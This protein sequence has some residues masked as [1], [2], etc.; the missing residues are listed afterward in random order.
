MPLFSGRT[1]LGV[2]AV[3]A[4][5]LG[6]FALRDVE[7][8]WVEA[9]CDAN[10]SYRRSLIEASTQHMRRINDLQEQAAKAAVIGAGR[11]AQARLGDVASEAE[12]LAADLGRVD[13]VDYK[14]AERDRAAAAARGIATA[15]RG[16]S[17]RLSGLTPGTFA[18][19]AAPLDDAADTY[20]RTMTTLVDTSRSCAG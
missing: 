15:A 19:T 2:V 12:S 6:G 18:A 11:E 10:P 13:V 4:L 8:P 20:N 9:G 5:I 3:I 1:I 14:R 7:Y 17:N 16:V